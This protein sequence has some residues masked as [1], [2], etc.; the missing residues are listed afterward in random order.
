MP[1]YNEGIY[2]AEVVHQ[3]LNVSSQKGTPGFFLRIQPEDGAYER[4][5]QWWITENT[6]DNVL[7]DLKRLGFV[8]SSWSQLDPNTDGFHD[9]SG[10]KIQAVCKHE[11]SPDGEKTYE[12][13]E[14]PY[15]GK[16]REVKSLDKKGARSLDNLFG[17][18][19]K[20]A[21]GDQPKPSTTAEMQREAATSEPGD[22]IPF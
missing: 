18:K 13:W 17:K 15:D 19:L 8:G 2:E 11:Q 6:V 21:I 3:G 22:D 14:L 16:P 10:Q 20:S 9:F 5:I 7:R 4:D 12:R 1:H